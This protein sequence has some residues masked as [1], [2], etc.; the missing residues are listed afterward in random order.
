[1]VRPRCPDNMVEFGAAEVGRRYGVYPTTIFDLE[2]MDL[3]AFVGGALMFS[4]IN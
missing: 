4:N 1:M 2:G 3:E